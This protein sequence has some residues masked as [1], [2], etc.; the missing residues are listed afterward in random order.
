M[1]KGGTT[2]TIQS[3]KKNYHGNCRLL[4]SAENQAHTNFL[5]PA[6]ACNLIF[7]K[8]WIFD[9]RRGQEGPIR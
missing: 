9:G 4:R 3:F 6:R 1:R 5:E 8:R 7:V 2:Q